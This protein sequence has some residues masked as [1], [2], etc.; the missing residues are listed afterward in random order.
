[1]CAVSSPTKSRPPPDRPKKRCLLVCARMHSP[2]GC[3]ACPPNPSP[4]TFFVYICMMASPIKYAHNAHTHKQERGPPKTHHTTLHKHPQSPHR[5]SPTRPTTTTASIDTP[6]VRPSIHPS[7]DQ[8]P[9]HPHQ[10]CFTACSC[11][12]ASHPCTAAASCPCPCASGGRSTRQ[13][14]NHDPM[15]VPNSNSSLRW[16]S[17]SAGYL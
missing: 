5:L 11:S 7:I 10:S 6:A 14:P 2:R 15:G 12:T 13:H 3:V 16:L 4:K 17:H 8:P 1:M 9:L